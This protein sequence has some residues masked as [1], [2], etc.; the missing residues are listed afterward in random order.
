MQHRPIPGHLIE[1]AEAF[2]DLDFEL[3]L[4]DRRGERRRQP[5]AG[6]EREAQDQQ[7]CGY[8]RFAHFENLLHMWLLAFRSPVLLPVALHGTCLL[9]TSDAADDLLCV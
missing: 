5:A 8:R 7:R 4:A 1:A 9:Y 3:R 2:L 6:R